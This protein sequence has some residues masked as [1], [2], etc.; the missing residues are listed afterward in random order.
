[1]SD[2]VMRELVAGL[3]KSAEGKI[4]E[5]ILY[6]SAARGT[7]G[8][9]SDIDVALLINEALTAEE[10]DLLSDFVVDM[11]LKYDTV[12]SVIDLPNEQYQSRKDTIPFYRNV[13]REGIVLWKAA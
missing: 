10:L 11:N 7:A 4:A 3:L 6:G 9:D 8:A 5:I 2:S 13:A 12:F 1:M